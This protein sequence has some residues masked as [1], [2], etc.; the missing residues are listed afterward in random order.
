MTTAKLAILAGG[1]DLPVELYQACRATGRPVHHIA[2]EGQADAQRLNGIPCD[3]S[4]PG[5]V[6]RTLNLLREA[7]AAELVLAGSFRRPSLAALRPDGVAMRLLARHGAR[8][9]SDDRLLNVIIEFIEKEA[10]IRVL[11]ADEVMQELLAPAGQLGAHAPSA[12]DEADIELGLRV[13]R[14]LGAFDIGQAVVVRHG[15]VLG[16]E[17]VEGTDALI[18]R[19]GQWRAEAPAGVLVKVRKPQQQQRADPPVIGPCTVAAVQA[20]GLAGIAVEAQAALILDRPEVVRLADAAGLFLLG[21]NV[22]S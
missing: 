9:L 19:C 20:A 3:W 1:G 6:E 22:R 15:I 17:A 16:V 4:R 7:G 11:A 18:V 12:E 2:F 21:V 14:Q 10:G 13:A 8:L 5:A